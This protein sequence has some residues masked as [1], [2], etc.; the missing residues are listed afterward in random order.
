[1][2]ANSNISEMA[3]IDTGEIRFAPP[4]ADMVAGVPYFANDSRF[5][6][7]NFSQPLTIYATGWKD[8]EN[9]KAT[10]DFIAPEVPTSRRFEWAK[11]TNAEEWL[12]E[13]DDVR[14]IGSDFKR[15]EFTASKVNDKTLNK[16]LTIRVD[17]D[18]VNDL[19]NWREIY[20]G[21]IMRRLLRNDL[22]RGITLLLAAATNTGKTWTYNSS[23][24]QTPDPD[25]D[26]LNAVAAFG[27]VAGQDA[28]RILMGF[29]AWATRKGAYNAL[30]NAAGYAGAARSAADIADWVGV[31]AIRVSRERYQS[32]ASAKSRILGSYVVAFMAQ[33]GATPE[34]PTSMKRFIS[35]TAGGT[36]FKVYEQR[37]S[38]HL[39]DIS[40]EHYSKV[41]V[42]STLGIQKLTIS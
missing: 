30:N 20:T 14:A 22:R 6:E 19:P 9:I 5:V 23:T 24:N 11:A 34:D 33:D 32:S 4:G 13:S 10:L 37:I 7:S 27:D 41:I 36:P 3:N 2:K 29:S 17:E 38:S 35:P 31:E 40:V 12:S 39:V 8:Q 42:T 28:N 25:L 1:M 21:R 18:N 26:M 15:V 16:G